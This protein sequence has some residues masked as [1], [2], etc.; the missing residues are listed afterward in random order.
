MTV[1][2]FKDKYLEKKRKEKVV[3]IVKPGET[4]QIT[5]SVLQT[6]KMEYPKVAKVIK[7][8]PGM[9]IKVEQ[10]IIHDSTYVNYLVDFPE[11]IPGY[12]YSDTP[13]IE[14]EVEGTDGYNYN[15][16][17]EGCVVKMSDY[18]SH[19]CVY[20][21]NQYSQRLGAIKAKEDVG[22]LYQTDYQGRKVEALTYKVANTPAEFEALCNASSNLV[23]ELHKYI[24]SD[25]W[26]WDFSYLESLLD[27]M[28]DKELDKFCE[29]NYAR[30]KEQKLT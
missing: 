4:P 15:L 19:G 29:V 5:R 3:S 10:T 27:K 12:S 22:L 23:K 25:I 1:Q 7:N 14:V 24:H 30:S 9:Q 28:S 17:L 21:R 6:V 13:R 11:E 8:S 26:M 18:G 16:I 2:E 20:A